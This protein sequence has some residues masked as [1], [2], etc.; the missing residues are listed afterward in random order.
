MFWRDS[1]VIN[2]TGIL[3][4]YNWWW[5][6]GLRWRPEK[7]PS[8]GEPTLKKELNA[9]HEIVK[10]IRSLKISITS[11]S[12]S[13]YS[14]FW[15]LTMIIGDG[16]PH[17]GSA[18]FSNW[19]QA[20]YL[21]PKGLY[22]YWVNFCRK[23]KSEIFLEPSGSLMDSGKKFVLTYSSKSGYLGINSIH[24]FTLVNLCHH[25]VIPY[26]VPFHRALWKAYKV[27]HLNIKSSERAMK[28][29]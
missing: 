3:D 23:N 4:V 8:F 13:T 18:L 1:Q 7:M 25:L 26:R 28:A 6:T 14:E 15:N 10:V 20:L 5:S 29:L 11:I 21:A 27:E 16:S 17:T 9:L 24:Y 12:F 2:R 19:N 22:R